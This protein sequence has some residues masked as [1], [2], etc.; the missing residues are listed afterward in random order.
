MILNRYGSIV[1][2]E[3][4]QTFKIRPSLKPDVF[5]VMPNHFHCIVHIANCGTTDP[6][7]ADDP[8]GTPW[9][10]VP[11]GITGTGMGSAPELPQTTKQPGKTGSHPINWKSGVLGAII[12]QFKI[13]VTK[14]IRKNG[15]PGFNWQFRFHDHIIRNDQELQRIREYI[16][17]NPS[18]WA[19]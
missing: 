15:Y 18:N 7:V 13:M 3:W 16:R 10:G 8:V 12:G 17:N 19:P 2:D 11:T 5:V 9:H 6:V 1:Y 14:R 4:Q